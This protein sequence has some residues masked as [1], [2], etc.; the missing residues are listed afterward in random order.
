MKT[1]IIQSCKNVSFPW[2]AE[3]M[4]SV[5][6]WAKERGYEYR[7]IEDREFMALA[8]DYP[9][10]PAV[11]RSDLARLR[12]IRAA[13]TLKRD[14][15]VYW[16]DSDFLIWDRRRFRLPEAQACAVVCARESWQ[17][18][19]RVRLRTNNCILGLCEREDAHTL[20]RASEIILSR[21]AM[22]GVRATLGVIGPDLF[23]SDNLPLKRI[24]VRSAGCF[25]RESIARILC[26]YRSGRRHRWWLALATGGDMHGANLCSSQYTG[27]HMEEL[28][29]ILMQDSRIALGPFVHLSPIYRTWIELRHFCHRAYCWTLT[30]LRGFRRARSGIA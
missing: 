9:E 29:D 1:L 19:D 20:V 22:T 24:E 15:Q 11:T 23:E 7:Q 10:F 4:H 26:D 30:R 5:K 3:C 14:L 8:A 27:F 17:Y 28:T 21:H 25:S 6:T 12:F 16:I 2:I 13:L 18:P